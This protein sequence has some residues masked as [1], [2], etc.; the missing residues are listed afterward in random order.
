MVRFVKLTQIDVIEASGDV[1]LYVN[2]EYITNFRK[3]E[4]LNATTIYF[5]CGY[6]TVRESVDEVRSLLIGNRD[7]NNNYHNF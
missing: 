4:K 7:R 2:P 1:E 6:A 3:N 5:V